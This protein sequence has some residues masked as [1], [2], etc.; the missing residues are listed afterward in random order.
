MLSA[1]QKEET[2]LIGGDLVEVVGGQSSKDKKSDK[3]DKRPNPSL[4]LC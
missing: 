3:D 2:H 1:Y 4:G